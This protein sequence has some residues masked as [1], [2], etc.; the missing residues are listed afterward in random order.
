MALLIYSIIN[1]IL[2]VLVT[3]TV[4]LWFFSPAAGSMDIVGSNENVSNTVDIE[5]SQAP[6]STARY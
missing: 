3:L 4:D 6:P 2:N 1:T 5:T